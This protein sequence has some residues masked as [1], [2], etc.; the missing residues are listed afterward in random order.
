MPVNMPTHAHGQG[1]TD[2]NFIIPELVSEVDYK[3]GTYYA[4]VGDFGSAGAFSIALLRRAAQWFVP[5]GRR[6][7]HRLRAG[8]VRHVLTQSWSRPPALRLRAGAQRR[9]LGSRGDNYQ[10]FNGVAALQRGRRTRT[11]QA[12]PPWPTTATGTPPTR[13][14][15]A[16][17]T[18]KIIDRFGEIDPTD[19][20]NSSR[21]GLNGDW[22]RGDRKR[23]NQ[24][25]SPTP[26]TTTSNCSRDFDYFL[27]DPVHGDQFQ[28]KGPARRNSARQRQPDVANG[29]ALR[30]SKRRTPMGL[31]ERTD[32]IRL[33]LNNTEGAGGVETPS[34]TIT[35]KKPASVRTLKIKPPGC[36][37]SAPWQV[38]APTCFQLP[39]YR[40]HRRSFSGRRHGRHRQPQAQPDF[41]PV[42][43]D[44]TCTSTPGMVS[45]P[46]MSAASS[47]RP[48]SRQRCTERQR[49]PAGQD[50]KGAEVGVRSHGGARPAKLARRSG[51]LD[52]DSELVFDGDAA[53]NEP[54]RPS[55]RFG[56]EAANFYT[57]TPWLT[58]DL[59]FSLIPTRAS[60]N[61]DP[62]GPWVPEAIGTVLD[63]GRRGPR[64][65][66]R[67][68]TAR[69][70]YGG[71]AAAFLWS[72]AI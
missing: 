10:K 69:G 26:R 32:F 1:Y 18:E 48:S 19:G 5:E 54:S 51:Y 25:W 31:Q 2:L 21:Y 36:R 46:T 7:R 62:A 22:H 52:L 27:T 38:S 41:W 61:H 42:V 72:S 58:L 17:F 37:G 8:R 66:G 11:A 65:S 33:Q 63:A 39:R 34:A 45:I 67:G 43:Q 6:R 71:L 47:A 68:W 40:L 13:C 57:P 23:A 16:P 29:N 30:H 70:L 15:S 3:K 20:G 9:P 53:D 12:S 44:G 35:W 14:P 4:N 24:A 49:D 64:C 28:Q 59:D 55:R 56:V 50:P 60:R